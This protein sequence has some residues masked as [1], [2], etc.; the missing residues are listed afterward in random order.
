M[1]AIFAFTAWLIAIAIHILINIP[2]GKGNQAMKYAQLIDYNMRNIFLEKSCIRSGVE[3]I[4]R[5]YIWII[6]R[7]FYTVYFNCMPS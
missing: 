3:T 4:P 2:R 7:E 1:K 5:A 6:S